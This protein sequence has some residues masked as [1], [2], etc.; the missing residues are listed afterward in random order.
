MKHL[1]LRTLLTI[2]SICILILGAQN[3]RNPL[4]TAFAL[5]DLTIN[6][7]V[8]S[9]NPIFVVNNM[10]PG[11]METRSVDVTNNGS[12]VRDVAVRGVKT[13]ETQQF[14]DILM[15]EILEGVNTLYGPQ[16][17]EQFFTDSA[18]P[19]G[20]PLSSLNSSDST[21]YTFKV[22]LPPE[23]GNQYQ[24]A[25]VIFDLIIGIQIDIPQECQNIDFSG[26]PIFGTSGNDKIEGGPGNDLI[27]GLEGHDKIEG[28][29]GD[30]C[31][32]GGLGHDKLVGNNGKDVILGQDGDD[33]LRGNNGEDLL[34][35]GEG[36]D[37][38]KGENENDTLI[39]NDGDDSLEGGNGNDHMDG[40]VGKD[41]L[42]GGNG[43]D[44]LD[45]GPGAFDFGKGGPA[46]DTCINLE[47]KKT[48]ELP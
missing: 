8:P 25:E 15:I 14:A 10:L 35:G 7:G 21:T 43:D 26:D 40:G 37:Q 39:G 41:S 38:L 9:G 47:S 13:S 22:T 28:N 17:L 34:I 46:I 45:G 29:L 4:S 6:W 42:D 31:I 30:D 23:A 5:G 48:C 12:A 27:F 20:I 11:D 32:V 18:D 36:K 1:R 44:F 33:S 3:F 19:T 24:S 16:S 2:L